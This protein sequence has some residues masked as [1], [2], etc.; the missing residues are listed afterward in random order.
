M[1]TSRHK[2]KVYFFLIVFTGCQISLTSEKSN[3]TQPPT[4]GKNGK[5]IVTLNHNAAGKTISHAIT[6]SLTPN[7]EI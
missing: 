5:V 6:Q 1:V 2:E 7:I 3:H 4:D